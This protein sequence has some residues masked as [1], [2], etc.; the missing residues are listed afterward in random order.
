MS[1]VHPNKLNWEK[2]N[3]I[4]FKTKIFMGETDTIKYMQVNDN[5]IEEVPRRGRWTLLNS[6]VCARRWR[7]KNKTGC[8]HAG[9]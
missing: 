6:F 5:N 4:V 1:G 7:I 9:S 3:E 2:D 8:H